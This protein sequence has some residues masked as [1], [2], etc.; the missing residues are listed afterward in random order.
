MEIPLPIRPTR[1]N[2]NIT[3]GLDRRRVDEAAHALNKDEHAYRKQDRGL[4]GC[5][6]DLGAAVAPGSLWRRR[7]ARERRRD[8]RQGEPGDVGEH[9][10]GVRQQRQAAGDERADDLEHQDGRGDRQNDGQGSA[11]TN[12]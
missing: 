1:A 12:S 5:G 6:E 10:A 11:V 4:S 9:V 8:D 3:P 7:T 2:A